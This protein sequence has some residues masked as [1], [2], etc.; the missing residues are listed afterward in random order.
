[1]LRPHTRI[2]SINILGRIFGKDLL[3][4]LLLLVLPDY[5]K[6]EILLLLK[7]LFLI[8]QEMLRIHTVPVFGDDLGNVLGGVFLGHLGI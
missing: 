4:D 3:Q 2:P 7:I 5:L 8:L 1:M 6:L